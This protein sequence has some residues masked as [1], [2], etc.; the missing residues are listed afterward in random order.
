MVN[1]GSRNP[2]Y[3]PN[4]TARVSRPT[5]ERLDAAAQ[6]HDRSIRQ[7]IEARIQAS[8]EGEDFAAAILKDTS[9]LTP[10][11]IFAREYGRILSIT[12]V[13]RGSKLALGIAGE[14]F[15]H[16]AL[17]CI[18][19]SLPTGY[20]D[21]DAN[22]TKQQEVDVKI[23]DESKAALDNLL[24]SLD[25]QI[26]SSSFNLA[27]TAVQQQQSNLD[28]KDHPAPKTLADAYFAMQLVK[29]VLDEERFVRRIKEKEKWLNKAT[30]RVSAA[31]KEKVATN[32]KNDQYGQW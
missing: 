11:V 19:G 17:S 29:D 1:T 5:K 3:Q 26:Q 9:L 31:P 7:E 16:V 13:Q 14:L 21:P 6:A 24:R 22:P 18:E 15:R 30:M 23:L 10:L 2:S 20:A 25:P 28:A 12:G 27:R 32:L 8:F 4:I